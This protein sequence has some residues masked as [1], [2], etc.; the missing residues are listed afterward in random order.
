MEVKARANGPAIRRREFAW[1][2]ANC[3]LS[4][5]RLISATGAVGAAWDDL[6]RV[7]SADTESGSADSGNA[8]S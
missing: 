6:W 4:R 2:A 3:P 1:R 7:C 5:L 8:S